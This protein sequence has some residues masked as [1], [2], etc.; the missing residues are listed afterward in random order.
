MG[1]IEVAGERAGWSLGA[2]W[3]QWGHEASS[4]EAGGLP[5]PLLLLHLFSPLRSEWSFKVKVSLRWYPVRATSVAPL[6]SHRQ[7]LWSG[8]DF[9]VL[10]EVSPVCVCS[11]FSNPEGPLRYTHTLAS[12]PLELQNLRPTHPEMYCSL[13]DFSLILTPCLRCH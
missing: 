10:S 13:S 12:F 3:K 6:C 4:E 2:M 1:I 8:L 7:S 9:R 5:H 11:L